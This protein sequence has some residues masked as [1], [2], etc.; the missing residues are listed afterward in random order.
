[1]AT[2]VKTPNSKMYACKIIEITAISKE[3][4]DCIQKEVRLHYMVKSEWCVRLY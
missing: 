1:M 3:D 2:E 4:M